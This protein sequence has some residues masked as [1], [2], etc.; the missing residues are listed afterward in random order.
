MP[1]G[2][3]SI[4]SSYDASRA[5]RRAAS[6]IGSVIAGGQL[7]CVSQLI[8]VIVRSRCGLRMLDSRQVGAIDE[9]ATFR[10]AEFDVEP[11]QEAETDKAVYAEA[12]GEVEDVHAKIGDPEPQRPES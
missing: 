9:H 5:P 3:V 2:A 8:S 11:A 7:S 6:T 1:G 10:E 4:N 12:V